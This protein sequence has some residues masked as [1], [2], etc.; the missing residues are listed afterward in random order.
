MASN[1]QTQRGTSWLDRTLDKIKPQPSPPRSPSPPPVDRTNWEHSVEAH[2]I[3]T[4][5]VHDVGLIVF[6]ETQSGTHSD[7][8]N[9]TIGG[10]RE[11]VA[12][13]VINADSQ[14]GRGRPKTAPATEPTGKAIRDPRTKAAYD[15]SLRA[16]REAYL[17]PTDPTQGA[18]YF[19]L[20]RNADR[21]DYKPGGP[22]GPQFK[23]RTQSGPFDNSF[24]TSGKQ[25][26]PP[27]GIYINTYGSK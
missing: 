16:A 25:G 7:K 27:H 17:S 24:P 9:D 14:F 4:L 23:I 26:L 3:N 2:K 1:A 19:N 5:T 15:S 20:R 11:K 13:A 12:H 8:A 22:H 6:N 21:S 10:A 18:T